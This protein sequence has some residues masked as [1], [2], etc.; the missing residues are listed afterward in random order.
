MV[1][2]LFRHHWI[3]YRRHVSGEV[4]PA[5]D[6]IRALRLVRSVVPGLQTLIAGHRYF[7][8]IGETVWI[9]DR[10]VVRHQVAV[11]AGIGNL[12]S[13]GE[14]GADEGAVDQARESVR[15]LQAGV[16]ASRAAGA[17]REERHAEGLDE[18][19]L[20]H[21]RAL[22]CDEWIATVRRILERVDEERVPLRQ[23]SVLQDVYALRGTLG[24][25]TARAA[26]AVY[27]DQA[28]VPARRRRK[29]AWIRIGGRIEK[30]RIL[31]DAAV[32]RSCFDANH[33]R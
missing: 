32:D 5:R 22:P 25:P 9:D 19:L 27:R 11:E 14:S 29:G 7:L 15:D 6:R 26:S 28:V 1:A 13:I 17:E 31:I 2:Q 20:A 12:G 21:H 10:E 8:V 33:L 30:D 16:R 23:I 24:V 3:P 4:H 18:V